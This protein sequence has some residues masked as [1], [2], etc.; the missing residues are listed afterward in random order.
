M[1]SL[2]DS[3][4]NLFFSFSSLLVSYPPRVRRP[5]KK[6]KE[7]EEKEDNNNDDD[8]DKKEAAT[9]TATVGKYDNE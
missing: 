2:T 9:A 1:G 5:D 7:E 4:L 6:I 3:G 8:T